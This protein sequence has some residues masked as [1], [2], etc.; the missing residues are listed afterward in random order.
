MKSKASTTDPWSCTE[1]DEESLGSQ[2][3]D[4]EAASDG[5]QSDAASAESDSD[6]EKEDDALALTEPQNEP[7]DYV[8]PANLTYVEFGSG[9]PIATDECMLISKGVVQ[10]KTDI[11]P[12]AVS[13]Q[14]PYAAV[15]VGTHV[16]RGI[17]DSEKMVCAVLVKATDD[18]EA[19][20]RLNNGSHVRKTE[21]IALA[22]VHSW[23]LKAGPKTTI[24]DRYKS[25]FA[26]VGTESTLLFSTKNAQSYL[27]SLAKKRRAE[28]AGPPSSAADA[29][30]PA[31]ATALT[32]T[33]SGSAKKPAALLL[34]RKRPPATETTVATVRITKKPKRGSKVRPEAIA[35]SS[36]KQLPKT[37]TVPVF[38]QEH[39]NI[40]TNIGKVLALFKTAV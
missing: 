26:V 20:K 24:P 9:A 37:K 33:P 14:M 34:Q 32:L 23:N 4:G 28:A 35:T 15:R 25:M 36:P 39:A 40:I 12:I 17:V 5:N 10:T 18:N 27:D 31:T 2:T 3:T 38:T 7:D 22:C 11:F 1:H 16:F 29:A 30:V 8:D 21:S 19:A 13:G 6:T